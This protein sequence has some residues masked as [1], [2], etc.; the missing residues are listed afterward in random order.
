MKRI[1][2]LDLGTNSIGWALI[3]KDFDKKEG[4]IKGL[5]SRIIPMSQDVLGKFDSGVSI[6]QTAERTGYRSVRRLYQR[7]ILRRE[8]LHRVLHVLGF[9]PKHY[10]NAIDFKKRLG[11]F[12]KHTEVKLN[13]CENEQGEFEFIFKNSFN[14][15]VND[16]KAHNQDVKI[17]YDW[18]LYY[19]RTKALSKKIT[20]EELAWVILNFNQK[21]GY[22][23]LRG[24]EEEVV[25]GKTKE[26]VALKVKS[27]VDSG[28]T[29]KKSGDKLYDVY[30]DNGWK[31]DKQIVKIENW[32]G[33]EK[34]FI[35]TSS[36]KK[37]G[38]V[39]R[40]YKAVDSEKDWVAIKAKME[41]D[42]DASKKHI[43]PYIYEA[44]LQNP[45]QKIRGK[46]IK[47]IERNY[48]K[49]EFKA[50]IEEQLKHHPELQS[51]KQ[52]QNCVQELYP[53][54]EAHQN[55][56]K[57]KGFLYLFT[58][59]IIFYQR[60]LKSKKSTISGCQYEIRCFKKK[61]VDKVTK[62]EKEIWVNEPLKSI[63]KSHP[64][65][66]EFRLWQF[67]KNL[68]VYQK[69]DATGNLMDKDITNTLLKTEEDWA[70]LFTFLSLKKEVDQKQLIQYFIAKKLIEKTNKDNYRWNYVEDKKYPC[71]ETKAQFVSR[72]QKVAS[73]DVTSFL[74]SE[75]TYNLWH[76]IYSVKDKEEY[77]KALGT[78]AKK[79][80]ID[81]STFVD[82]FQKFPPFPN[83]Y[84]AYSEKS[85]KKLL[86]LMR[87]GYYYKEEHI[88]TETKERIHSIMERVNS[89][90]LKD[91]YTK[92]D[93]NSIL[94]SV[95]DDAIPI[96]LIKSF[97]PF[98]NGN[99]FT[100]L[101]TYQACYAVYNRH[102]EPSTITQWKS[103]QD[104]TQFLNEFKQHSLRNPI[105][106]QVVTETLRTVRDIWNHYGKGSEN[107]FNKIHVELG[108][109]MKSPAA[110]R[111]SMSDRNTENENT[112]SR[113]KNILQE[114]MNDGISNVKAYSP[115]H[116][117]ILKIYEEGIIQNPDA[118]YRKVSEDDISK[119]RK[120][121]SPTKKEI[122]KY[123]LWLE[124]GYVSPYTG[125]IIQLSR[126]FTIDYEIEHVIPQ[127][128]YFDNSLGNKVICESEV[129]RD[130]SNM[131]AYE[132]ISKNG[133]SIV[134]GT[135]IL[136]LENY[137]NHC[138]HYFKK[139]RTKLR[140]LLSEEIPEGFINRQLNDSR[141]ISKLIKGL[142]GNLVRE[143]NEKEAISKHVVPVTGAITS[144]LKQDWG[145]NEK[146]NELVAPRFMRLNEMTNSKD[147]GDWDF[148]KDAKGNNTGKQFFRTK[149]PDAISKGF[150]KKRIDHRHH[151]LDALV[152]A[153][154]TQ[155]HTHYL[156][157]LNA[158]EKNYGLRDALLIKNKEGHYTKHFIHPWSNFTVEAK[159]S[160]E[161]TIVSFKQNLRV[162]N[163][164]NN[165]TW[166][167]VKKEGA[168]K[169]V[170]VKQTKG[171]NWA[172]R[173]PM[174]K[175]TVSGKVTLTRERKTPISFNNAIESHQLI[176]N[177]A[178]KLK[179]KLAFKLFDGDLGKVKKYFKNNPIEING[180]AVNKVTVYEK[181]E[182]T[183]T[184]VALSEKFTQKQLQS[185]TDLGIQ[186]ILLN[187][188][189]N[190]INEEGKEDFTL[191]FNFGGIQALNKSMVQLNKGKKHQPIYK[192]RLF[193]EG[194]KF[195]VSEEKKSAK[196]T[197]YV[198]AAKGTNLYFA[199]YF[200]KEKKK[201]VFDTIPLN[202]VIEHQKWRATITNKEE[203]K[204]IPMIPVDHTKGQFMFSLSPNDLVYV[205]TEEEIE[206]PALVDFDRLKKEQVGRIYKMVS[207]TQ[208]KLQC[209]PS[210]VATSIKNKFE[211][212]ALNKMER[213]ITGEMIKEVC[214][215]IK[216]DRLGNIIETI[217]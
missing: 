120:N 94:E 12:K 201:R 214:W 8:R 174:H 196:N 22:Y 46:L 143:D 112:N 50:I 148:Q 2:G 67:L 100:G 170:L 17:P 159:H 49:K 29:I 28:E 44:L 127:S 20:K 57:K 156:N 168:F 10:A 177:K 58:E 65:F 62:L 193:E 107:F 37:D 86:P 70:D 212:S 72:L 165:K 209:V 35:V 89:L 26:F 194:S 9:L 211:F 90:K 36:I 6:S 183:A 75:I 63:P 92:I 130:K 185:I 121:N 32:E 80:S 1:L 98:K 113:I 123:K 188:L 154:C 76:I 213:S 117:E 38:E 171:D 19:L 176:V 84:G 16:F 179:V 152:I 53:R 7:N 102:S 131:T 138:N 5:G 3:E 73:L 39:K 60:P 116:Q 197:K 82:R 133:G 172:I 203:S 136:E 186:K 198:E 191:A 164:T 125:R 129:N 81:A 106:E 210:K 202:E 61:E 21:R 14:E 15:M 85:I 200:N 115:S 206:N 181:I 42:I 163:K 114:L 52:Y 33:K 155:K 135:P 178:I 162:I 11:Q 160:L 184:R 190:Y 157:A 119:I 141:Y 122:E 192:V 216:A 31:Y 153:C 150:N 204:N 124:Q 111:K 83:D 103:P 96:R 95:A 99:P 140:N 87:R 182:A 55:N 139:N 74:T 23:Q 64:L 134:D 128:R 167:W 97:M 71:N 137:E 105:V 45:T 217:K 142:L 144:K 30:F 118:D 104:I 78:F 54:N 147:F 18:T 169:K 101:N 27:L 13:Y 151:A 149:V 161:T 34:E 69:E 145:L 47:T 180:L 59:D 166:Q 205:P 173:K 195:P 187:H 56:I 108:R 93:L 189:K 43:G 132:Y 79:H 88:S 40:T 66:Q 158:E 91:N 208:N 41:Q 25:E 48:Y 68:T 51:E 215:K 199:M 77:E 146:W 109:E 24:E 207:T 175:E 126:L 110:K 4:S